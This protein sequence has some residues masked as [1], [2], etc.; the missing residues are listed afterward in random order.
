VNPGKIVIHVTP[1]VVFVV[2]RD[3]LG[4][5]TDKTPDFITLY[6]LAVQVAERLV[7]IN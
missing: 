6:P 5:A 2:R 7:L 1:A 4:L 3:V